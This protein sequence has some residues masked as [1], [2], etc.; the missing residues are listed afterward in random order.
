MSSSH[1]A[2]RQPVLHLP[3]TALP[4]FPTTAGGGCPTVSGPTLSDDSR[5]RLSHSF[6]RKLRHTSRPKWASRPRLAR[7][8]PV[9]ATTPER[10]FD[11]AW[12]LS[13]L[14]EVHKQLVREYADAGRVASASSSG[15]RVR[16][17]R[18]SLWFPTPTSPMS[19][20]RP[21]G[22]SSRRRGGSVSGSPRPSTTPI[23]EEIHDLFTA[24]EN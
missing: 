13:L 22:R 3:A 7:R 11:L 16:L 15:F 6:R 24:I 9:D 12:A 14:D 21:R 4:H 10:L 23:D 17:A 19:W 18:G 5:G 8:E 1:L 20:G 2:R